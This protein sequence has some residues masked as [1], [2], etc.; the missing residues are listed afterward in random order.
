[1][2]HV[3]FTAIVLM[4]LLTLKMLM[5]PGKVAFNP[6]VNK[7]RWLLTS[8]IVLLGI[9]F[10]L[11]YALH[12][13]EMG[14]TQAVMLNLLL[15]IPCSWMVSIA[16]LHLQGKGDVSMTDRWIGGVI[17]ILCIAIICIAAAI[18]GQPLWSDTPEL[19][20]GEIICSVLYAAM[21]GHYAYRHATNL[22]NMHRALQNY[23]DREMDHMLRW[24]KLS[25]IILV[26]LAL[27]VPILIFGNG[28]WLAIYGIIFFGGIFYLVDSFCS[29]V[30]SSAPKRMEEAEGSEELSVKSEEITDADSETSTEADAAVME[31]IEGAV[32]KWVKKGG[33]LKSGMKLPIAAKEIGVPQYQLTSWLRQQDLKYTDWIT[34]L[35]IEEAKRMLL[36]HPEWTSETIADYCGFTSREYFHRIFRGYV[37][38]TPSQYQQK[39]TL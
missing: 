17:W 10:L 7:A 21:Q 4:A 8:G 29:Y 13:R 35:R 20:T 11:Q 23:Y 2:E 16:V 31:I 30:V 24:M 39:G 6:M 3:Q 22:H 15:F 36:E 34:G 9:H 19:R 33:Y 25:V 18:D 5:L 38:M 32:N 28:P 26:V 27:M 1:M 14:V 12:L 37:G